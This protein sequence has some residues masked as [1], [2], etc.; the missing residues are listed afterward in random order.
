MASWYNDDDDEDDNEG[1][2]ISFIDVQANRYRNVLLVI[3]GTTSRGHVTFEPVKIRPG[4]IMWFGDKLY[5]VDTRRGIRIFDLNHIYRVS[6]G[7]DIGYVGRGRY[8][9]FNYK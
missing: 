8:E 3:P 9:A 7:D 4:G 2:R 1:V 6:I 5:V